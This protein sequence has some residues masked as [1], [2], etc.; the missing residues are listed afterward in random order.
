MKQI[1]VQ[2]PIGKS[3]QNTIPVSYAIEHREEEFTRIF[4][5]SVGLPPAQLPGWL[6][7]GQFELVTHVR[8]G[9]HMVDYNASLRNQP[10]THEA[11][12]FWYKVYTEIFFHE[13]HAK[14]EK[15]LHC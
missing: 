2:F 7:N 8:D 13:L 1:H 11:D 9:V 12:S 6:A 4:R 5:C 10:R 15:L 3:G 14:R